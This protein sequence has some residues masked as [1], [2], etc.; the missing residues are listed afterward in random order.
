MGGDTLNHGGHPNLVGSW[1]LRAPNRR[2][3]PSHRRSQ[4]MGPL[5]HGGIRGAAAGSGGAGWGVTGQDG[6]GQPAP[7]PAPR[8]A[9]PAVTPTLAPAGLLGLSQQRRLCKQRPQRAEACSPDQPLR[10]PSLGPLVSSTDTCPASLIPAGSG[11][12]FGSGQDQVPVAPEQDAAL[13]RAP[14]T[15][16]GSGGARSP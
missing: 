12:K 1:T 4:P 7:L 5:S 11:A 14:C 10:K 6:G 13:G 3:H 9:R 2:G 16:P 15:G 8:R